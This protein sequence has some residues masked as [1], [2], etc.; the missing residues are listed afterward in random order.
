METT[1]QAVRE[2]VERFSDAIAA[3][4]GPVLILGHNYPDPDCMAAAI[5]MEA[6]LRTRC[7]RSATLSFGGGLGRAENRA[8]AGILDIAFE[9]AETIDPCGFAGQV[10]VD[11]Q[12]G[13]GNNHAPDDLPVLGVFDHHEPP[14]TPYE[15]HFADVRTDCGSSS[16]ILEEYL[17]GA[18]VS[19]DDRLATALLIGIRTDTE[20]LE[21]DESDADV[22]AYLRLYPHVNRQRMQQIMRPALSEA[23]FGVLRQALNVARRWGNAVI[24][25]LGLV[26]APDIL[27]EVSEL[28]TRLKEVELSLACGV[29]GGRVHFSLRG[30]TVRKTVRDLL[31]D[32]VGE[33]GS[34]GGHGRAAGGVLYTTDDNPA[35]VAAAFCQAFVVAIDAVESGPRPVCLSD[36]ERAATE[37]T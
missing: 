10:L 3:T 6:F 12:P 4:E 36:T 5:G 26:P 8:M 32:I 17:R 19:V 31:S 27:S 22:A 34:A 18:G 16:T 29:Y 14:P 33:R 23:Y 37:R 21:R 7:E 28:F 35:E 2:R 13:S 11:T 24:A 9:E 20:D 1:D 15:A 30:R 25:D